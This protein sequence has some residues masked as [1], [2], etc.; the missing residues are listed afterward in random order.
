MKIKK[1]HLQF[2]FLSLV[3]FYPLLKFDWSSKI[4]FAF[5]LIVIIKA[6][7]NKTIVFKK[8]DVSKF[9]LLSGFFICLFLSGL[10]SENSE[11]YFIKIIKIAPLIVIPFIISF[12]KLNFLNKK[13][14]II[15]RVFVMVNILYTGFIT[16]LFYNSPDRMQYDLYHYL[17]D[18]DKF[19]LITN[20]NLF[21]DFY[22]V[23]KP[24]FSMGFVMCAVFSLHYF[25]KD[26]AKNNVLK[27][28]YFLS[29]LYFT[30]WVFYAFSFPNVLAYLICILLTINH[31]FKIRQ[32]V[33][34]S[35]LFI[36]CC[37]FF[38]TFKSYDIDVKRGYN[39]LK[40]SINKENY[41][42]NDSRKEVYKSVKNILQ[43]S[44]L[45]Q[46][47]FGYGLGDVQDKLNQDYNSRLL[48]NSSRN[49]LYYSEEFDNQ[50]WFKN[51][52]TVES[53]K[54]LIIFD[55][56]NSELIRI[57]NT[58]NNLSHN[59]STKFKPNSEEIFTFSVFVK[60]KHSKLFILR[61]GNI[62]QRAV[63]DINSGEVF[64]K[65]NVL[66]ANIKSFKGGWFRC[67][68]TVKLNKEELALIGLSN[69][70]GE[71]VFKTDESQS[72]FLWG[73]QIETGE[74]TSYT[75]NKNELLHNALNKELNSHNNYLSFLLSGGIITL[76]SFLCF[77]IFLFKNSLKPYNLL[78]LSFCIIISLN[79]LTEN[80]LSRHWGLMFVSFMLIL[81]FSKKEKY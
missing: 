52:I 62:N 2:F 47:I 60:S 37:T 20:N 56:Q 7:H 68:I 15:F 39:F 72:L 53:N 63:F 4:L 41:E 23:H 3:S 69:N 9:F 33:L 16:Y 29:F 57:D 27:V 34:F 13:K 61:L 35:F 28:I 77:I 76:S 50:F 18:Y 1:D 6:I 25:F 54:D 79:F 64:Q 70:E 67:S 19:Q 22:L 44:S 55:K 21:N 48:E 73:A 49:K 40:S 80:I 71:Y 51:N 5:C 45:T 66:A 17:L 43:K 78:R 58:D 8:K 74:L 42:L 32:V 65:N 36:A 30:I 81:L 11:V 10:Y 24:Y 46:L 59:I 26:K 38:F 75:K 31:H 12:I 14:H